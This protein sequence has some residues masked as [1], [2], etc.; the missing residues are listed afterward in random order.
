MQ[1]MQAVWRRM[2][3]GPVS[4]ALQQASP[5]VLGYIPVGFAYGVLA[6]K[7]GLEAWNTML[8]SVI[9]FAGSAQLIAVGM[10]A[11]AAAPL[12]VVLTTFIVNLRHLLMSAALAPYLK[13]WRP[14]QIAAMTT[15]L[16]DETFALHAGR[17]AGGNT[18]M[19]E[20]FSINA[21]SHSA[22][23]LGTWLGLAA[24][25][26]IRDVRPLG[27][28]YALPAMFLALL[29]A[30]IRSRT[31]LLVAAL[32]GVLAVGLY[33]AGLKQWHVILAT[34]VAATVGLGVSQWTSKASS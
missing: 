19:R 33:A 12:A 30:Q 15:E 8:M 14:L 6:Q 20:T 13:K 27:L 11:G 31:H 18:D 16:T 17:F 10:L 29:V 25:E 9:V 4:A 5:I 3:E 32:S 7:A 26:L 28:D 1:A 23:V 21:I 22:W 34:V 24:S 2:P